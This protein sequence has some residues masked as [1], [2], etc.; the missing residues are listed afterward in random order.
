MGKWLC[1][2]IPVNRSVHLIQ[3]TSGIAGVIVQ[4]A[5]GEQIDQIKDQHSTDL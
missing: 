1:G 5:V 2:K 4:V 3:D